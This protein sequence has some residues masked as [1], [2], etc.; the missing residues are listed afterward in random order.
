M[1]IVH[2]ADVHI[3]YRKYAKTNSQGVNQREADVSASFREACERIAFLNPDLVVIAGDLFHSVRPSNANLTFVFRELKK[4]TSRIKAPVIIIAGNHETP[5][6]NDTGSPLLILREIDNVFVAESSLEWFTFPGLAVCALPHAAVGSIPSH[7]LRAKD[8][9]KRNILVSHLQTGEGWL[10]DLGGEER[11]LSSLNLGEWD[12][13][14]LGHVHSMKQ[15]AY[16]AFYSGSLEHT[17]FNIWAENDLAK[18]FIEY[19]LEEKTWRF[20]ELSSP[21]EILILPSLDVTGKSVAETQSEIVEALSSKTIKGKLV[22]IVVKGIEREVLRSLNH[23]ELKTFRAEALHFI[24]VGK[25]DRTAI[26]PVGKL[27][28]ELYKFCKSEPLVELFKGYFKELAKE[29]ELR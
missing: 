1:R 28:D 12:Y 3:G 17:S 10:S 2:L 15:V 26:A 20:H 14:A 19:D 9:Y 25:S 5:K 7:E 21:R 13:V 4:L 11:L 6:R 29:E 18:G 23:K 27:E 22:K 8:S 16:N 24:P